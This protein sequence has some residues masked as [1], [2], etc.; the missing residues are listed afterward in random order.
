MTIYENDR[1]VLVVTPTGRDGPMIC[2]L[3]TGNDVTCVFCKSSETARM[4]LSAGAAA[5]VMAE[6][7]LT[8]PE[9]AAWATKI[10]DQPSWSDLPLILLTVAGAVDV[11]NRRKALARRPLGNLVLL[12]RPVRP[13]TLIGT[14]QAALRS[15][16]R[17]YQVRDLM[18]QRCAAEEALRKVEKLAVAARLAASFSHEI[19]NPL[20]SVTNLLYL[21][22]LSSSLLDT[23]KYAEV[24][25][26]EL[27]RV[28]EIVTRNLRFHR[29]ASKPVTVQVAQVANAAL[30]L[31]EARLATSEIS[32]ER[33]FR[34]CAPVLGVVGELRQ[35]FS[36]L[37]GNALDATARGGAIKIRI[38]G[39]LEYK[40]G[41]R[42][43][44]RVTVRDTGSGI[45]P[46]IRNSLFEPFVSTKGNTATGL[47]LWV[48][49]EIVRRHEGTIQV[50]S[51]ARPPST[52]TVF[53]VFL[54]CHPSWA[55]A[56]S[57]RESRDYQRQA[58]HFFT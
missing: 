48:S 57:S 24:A 47:G 53:S 18:V 25:S 3:L 33:D 38:A 11:E 45:R 35:L 26:R 2:N 5:V 16:N 12:E 7:V 15:R 22:G 9:I 41:S 37:I 1:R 14:V 20:A 55:H 52:G 31:Y 21:I 8:L 32:I 30:S 40:N 43:G 28:S 4:E 6:E 29:G 46:E 19:N 49:S 23:R 42:P 56:R 27:A 10:S 34:E 51:R 39:A 36:N 44:I 58:A 17:Q 54:P 50:K 13:E